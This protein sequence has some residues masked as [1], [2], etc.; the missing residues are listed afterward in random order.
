MFKS[1][2]ATVVTVKFAS[3]STYNLVAPRVVDMSETAANTLVGK[4]IVA[5]IATV[6]TNDNNLFALNDFVLIKDSS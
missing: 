4:I 1:S 6:S 2:F 3:T 5:N